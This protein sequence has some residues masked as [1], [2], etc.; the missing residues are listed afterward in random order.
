MVPLIHDQSIGVVISGSS[1]IVQYSY[2]QYPWS[3]CVVTSGTLASETAYYNYFHS[4]VRSKQ[5]RPT[6]QYV[7][8]T[9]SPESAAFLK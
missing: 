2:K 6:H 9:I 5:S 3:P 8:E 4:V 7:Y 1:N